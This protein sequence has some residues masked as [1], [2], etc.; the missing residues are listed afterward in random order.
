MNKILSLIAIIFFSCCASQ[1]TKSIIPKNDITYLSLVNQENCTNEIKIF[2]NQADFNTFQSSLTKTGPRS[3]PLF[4]V[5][6]TIKNIAVICKSDIEA[7]QIKNIEIRKKSNILN[8][9]KI[10]GYENYGNT[11]N[12][13]LLEIPKQINTL[14]L[15]K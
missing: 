13:L 7:Y 3:A 1:Q 12:T 8:L 2:N 4:L 6:F 5:D 11:T 14:E 15:N 10:K 9:E